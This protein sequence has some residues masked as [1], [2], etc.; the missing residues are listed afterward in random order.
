MKVLSKYI[1]VTEIV[2]KETTAASGLFNTAT[3]VENMRYQE[4][5]VVMPGSDV[6]SVKAGETV[7]YDRAQGHHVTID[8]VT[9]RVILERDVAVV[10]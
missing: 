5:V 2:A 7:V 1:L 6:E 9:Y 3:A 10:L 8:N 4:A